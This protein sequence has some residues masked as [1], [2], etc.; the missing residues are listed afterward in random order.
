[1]GLILAVYSWLSFKNMSAPMFKIA[2][3]SLVEPMSWQLTHLGMTSMV[4]M[5]G[6]ISL[7][8]R[9]YCFNLLFITIL[10]G[11]AISAGV[12]M[13]VAFFVGS[14][15]LAIAQQALIH[16]VK[17]GVAGVI[18]F[19]VILIN[20]S[21]YF[22]SLY[23]ANKE[24][25]IMGSTMLLVAVGGELGRS[26]NLIVGASLR[27]CGDAKY[28]SVVGFASMWFIALPLAWYFGVHLAW[29]LVGVWLGASIDEAIR[30]ISSMRCWHSKRRQSKGL[31]VK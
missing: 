30:G 11:M 25:F 9:I 4:V 14:R 19:M 18:F 16:E 1:M 31:Y 27:A 10:Y 2:T 21:H 28:T 8:T 13:K 5:M 24:I 6:S 29:G 20:F 7:A 23:T 12:Q 22:F 17:I 26:F 15:Q 3:P